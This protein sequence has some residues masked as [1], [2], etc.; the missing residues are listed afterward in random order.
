[1][2][3][4]NTL[5]F[6][7]KEEKR[8]GEEEIKTAGDSETSGGLRHRGNSDADGGR[9]T[10]TCMSVSIYVPSYSCVCHLL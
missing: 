10:V 1:M 4:V 5:Y 8:K 9:D 7:Q 2:C 6:F 3:A